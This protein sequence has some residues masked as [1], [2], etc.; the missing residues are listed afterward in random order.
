MNQEVSLSPSD[1]GRPLQSLTMNLKD[2][3]PNDTNVQDSRLILKQTSNHLEI[4]LIRMMML[5]INVYDGGVTI[6]EG[7]GNKLK[8]GQGG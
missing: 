2:T 7:K 6:L 5:L 4:S 8:T 3:P 1:I